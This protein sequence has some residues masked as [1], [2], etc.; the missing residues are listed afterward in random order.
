MVRKRL[1]RNI[2]V[3]FVGIF[4]LVN[5]SSGHGSPLYITSGETKSTKRMANCL[6][7]SSLGMMVTSSHNLN[8]ME[9]NI[10]PFS[11][12]VSLTMANGLAFLLPCPMTPAWNTVDVPSGC[13]GMDP[14]LRFSSKSLV[15][16]VSNGVLCSVL[17]G[18]VEEPPNKFPRI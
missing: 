15:L 7:V 10:R 17:K 2:S 9:T 4:Y 16:S 5:S 11:L 18:L 14:N 12:V 6:Y 8:N 13:V 3:H 1:D